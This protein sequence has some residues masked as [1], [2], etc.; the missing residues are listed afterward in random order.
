MLNQ[1]TLEK[2]RALRLHGMAESFRA[3][4]EQAVEDDRS[5]DQIRFGRN[6]VLFGTQVIADLGP[7]FDESDANVTAPRCRHI[8]NFRW[9]AAQGVELFAHELAAIALFKGEPD[10]DLPSPSSQAF[11]GNQGVARVMTF[12][13]ENHA[14]SR[15]RQKFSDCP[16]N[17]RTCLIH[18]CFDF[19]AA[20][21]SRFFRVSHLRRSENRRVQSA[22]PYFRGCARFRPSRFRGFLLLRRFSP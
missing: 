1:Q 2:L 16:C 8:P 20:R 4:S 3:Q 21:E 22:L 18:Q 9:C 10:L 13:G 7:K 11:R 19:N 15:P 5:A 6:H 14:F 12:S 17:A